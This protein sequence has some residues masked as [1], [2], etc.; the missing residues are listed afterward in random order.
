MIATNE[1]VDRARRWRPTWRDPLDAE[2]LALV[3]SGCDVDDIRN[4]L[5]M[6]I[7]EIYARLVRLRLVIEDVASQT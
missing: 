2:L 4:A 3:A 5:E 6:P 7:N 1:D